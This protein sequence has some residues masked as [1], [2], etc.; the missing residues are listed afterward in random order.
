MLNERLLARF[1]KYVSCSS[2]SRNEREFCL[3][4]EDELNNL[5]LPVIRQEI[6]DEIGSNGWNIYS[7]LEGDPNL[8]P[9]LFCLHLD[10][11]APCDNVRPVIEDGIIRSSGD[12]ILGADGKAAIAVVLETLNRIIEQDMQHRPVELVLHF[13]EVML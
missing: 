5:G 12:T 7:Y 10:T 6:G 3:M 1:L 9:I 8:E 13:E 11:V 4:V 2:E